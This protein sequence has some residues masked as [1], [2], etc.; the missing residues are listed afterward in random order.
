[1]NL[2]DFLTNNIDKDEFFEEWYKESIDSDNFIESVWWEMDNDL[3]QYAAENDLSEDSPEYKAYQE[4]TLRE[5]SESWF[6][7]RWDELEENMWDYEFDKVI[8][9]YRVITVDNIEEFIEISKNKKYIKKFKGLGQ[10]WSWDRSKAEAHWSEGKHEILLIGAVDPK[11]IEIK[12][13][14]HKNFNHS[15]GLEEAELQLSEGQD[16]LL[17]EILDTK[18]GKTYNINQILKI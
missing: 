8:P 17:M 14:M 13:S 15:L 12:V 1:M 10:F 18:E 16:I 11:D 5:K 3:E 7:D 9:V 4:K 2:F 6:Q